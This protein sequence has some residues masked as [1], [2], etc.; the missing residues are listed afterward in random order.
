MILPCLPFLIFLLLWS[1]NAL[2]QPL[3]PS[4]K[5]TSKCGN[6]TIPFPFAIEESCVMDGYFKV[7]CNSS[8]PYLREINLEVLDFSLDGTMRV[9]YS[10]YNTCDPSQNI[11]TAYLKT[12]PFIFS[13]TKN[14]IL[15][16]GCGNYS[17]LSNDDSVIAQC[18]TATCGKNGNSS[19]YCQSTIGSPLKGF[20]PF[21]ETSPDDQEC[22]YVALVEQRFLEQ[23]LKNRQD[24]RSLTHVP[25]VL[26]WSVL[27]LSFDVFSRN[28]SKT[29]E[30]SSACERSA[31]SCFSSDSPTVRC[32][33]LRGFEGNPYLLDGCQ[34]I[35]ECAANSN[36]C[37]SQ[38]CENFIGGYNCYSSPSSKAEDSNVNMV[39]LGLST[40]FGSLFLLIAAWWMYT[41]IKR[42]KEIKLK[43]KYFKR[44][45][46][47]LLQQQLTSCS[48]SVDTG[49]IFNANELDKATDHF[50]VDR[51]LGQGGQGTVYKGML[52]D[53]RIVAVK[54]SKVVDKAKL[55]EFINEVAILSQ[56]NHR[57]VVKLLGC[58]LETE[59]PLL[60]YEFIHNG[61]LFQYLQEQNEELPFTWDIRLRVAKEVAGA[62]SYLHSAASS[63][64]YHRDIKSSN[65]LLDDKYRAKVADF[66]TSRSVPI[67]NTHVT[68]RVQGTFGYFDPEYFRSNHFTDKSDV[69]SFGVVLVELLTGQK[70]V[71]STVTEEGRSLASYFINS[72]EEENLYDILDAQVKLGKEE[73]IMAMANLAFRCL[74][75]HGKQRPTMKEVA[76]ELEGIRPPERNSNVQVQHNTGSFEYEAVEPWDSSTSTYSTLDSVAPSVDADPLLN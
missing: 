36:I 50:N 60:V 15:G 74:N 41:V 16:V 24:L 17:F 21:I 71:F 67:D 43:E 2:A 53:G 3:S 1:E 62:L 72:M 29:Y 76:M 64:I 25:V 30:S 73:E 61:T 20:A 6:I 5:C 57:N 68:T 35:D 38:T 31:C 9:S 8:K 37:G 39:I 40:S 27:A 75:L 12:T 69:Y 13:Q 18:S 23:N 4:S 54:K 58:C 55:Q 63:P 14:R 48:G 19:S 34:D 59:V 51:I 66:G 22:H 56:I 28:K 26:E 42:R 52:A 33:C 45:G 70:P 11:A 44:N 47:L 49:K 46:G 65:I 10:V 32:N 7:D